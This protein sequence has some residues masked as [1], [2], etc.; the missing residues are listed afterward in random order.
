V[1]TQ[2]SHSKRVLF[3]TRVIFGTKLSFGTKVNFSLSSSNVLVD[4]SKDHLCFSYTERSKVYVESLVIRTS[5][6]LRRSGTHFL[7]SALEPLYILCFS[8]QAGDVPI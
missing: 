7:A 6:L 3:S 2:L 5:H 1:N 8:S 4:M